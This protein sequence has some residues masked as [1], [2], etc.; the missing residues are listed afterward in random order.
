M[1]PEQVLRKRA[2]HRSDIFSLGVVLYEMVTGAPP[3]TGTDLNAMMFQIVNAEPARPG[4]SVAGLPE[5][6]DSI[7]SK[8]LAKAPEDRYRSARELAA[9]LREC[10]RRMA[11]TTTLAELELPA[12]SAPKVS[13]VP[14]R[15]LSG[16]SAVAG[17]H[18]VQ[19]PADEHARTLGLS[20]DFDSL[21][22]TARLA[23]E[24]GVLGA[25]ASYINTSGESKAL[26]A[27][28]KAPTA[29]EAPPPSAEHTGIAN[30]WTPTHRLL[31]GASVAVAL[32]VAVLIVVV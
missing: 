30:A 19:G 28:E 14:V 15:A 12:T 1:S 22:A 11:A 2:E 7:V 18:D 27:T 32:L 3:F 24:T 6:L 9:D 23:A 21:S 13:G 8:A 29:A 16:E 26:P 5:T 10:R 25:F 31:F 20:K 4:T 17:E